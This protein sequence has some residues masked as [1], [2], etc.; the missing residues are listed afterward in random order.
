MTLLKVICTRLAL[1][2]IPAAIALSPGARADDIAPI[3]WYG[4]MPHPYIALCQK[5]AEAAAKDYNI[6]IDTTVGQ[7]W[8]Q[9]N[10]TQNIEQQSAR[11]Y[12]AVSLFP[13]DPTG[14]NGLAN[15]LRKHGIFVVS[16][17]GQPHTPTPISFTV[18]TDIKGAA[19]RATEDLIKILGDKGNI[20]NI[21][22]TVTDV[23]TKL[24]D[25][26]IHE[27]VAEHPNV[28]II[29]TISDMTQ[30]SVARTKIESALAARGNEIDG[31]I[32]TGYN[33]TVAAS[34]LLTE[35]HKN[36]SA[37]QYHFIGIDTDPI[38]IQAIRDG[39]IDGTIA[40]NPFAHGYI[41]CAILKLMLDG[42][43]P[44]KPYQLVDA[45]D[46]LVTKDNVDTYEQQVSA[47][48]DQLKKDLTTK[49]LTK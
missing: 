4:M 22:E 17:G 48:T 49:Y 9:A 28:H 31:I 47:I 21:L 37:K 36:A 35:R 5:G 30:Q 40:Q 32:T 27:V 24:R 11:G 38:T 42:Y 3:L 25:D 6:K 34:E 41:S 46:V 26:G 29:Q 45:G 15:S 8:S 19:M 20:L 16:Y 23:N 43:K 39:A 44:V 13:G 18:G 10:E 33:P 1:L 14:V 7:E 2:L 12:K